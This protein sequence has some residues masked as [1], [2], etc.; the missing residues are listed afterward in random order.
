MSGQPNDDRRRVFATPLLLSTQQSR[1]VK[2][3]LMSP[4]PGPMAPEAKAQA[5]RWQLAMGPD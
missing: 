5:V 4:P 1:V 3:R 2:G